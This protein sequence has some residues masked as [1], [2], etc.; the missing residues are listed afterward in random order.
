MWSKF[1]ER[2]KSCWKGGD[3]EMKLGFKRGQKG[4]TLVEIIIVLAIMAVLAAIVIPNVTNFLDEGKDTS[5]ESDQDALQV[6]VE[7]YRADT[8]NNPTGAWPTVD[9]TTGLPIDGNSDGDYLDAEDTRSFIDIET[10]GTDAYLKGA[11]DVRSA[12]NTNF[13]T[14]ATNTTGS[15]GWY[16]DSNGVVRSVYWDD[17][18]DTL[19]ENGA[20]TAVS[21]PTTAGTGY[22]VGDAVVLSAAPTGGVTATAEVASVGGT[23]DI[24]GVDVVNPGAGYTSAPTVDFSGEGN[25]DASGSTATIQT[26]V[27]LLG[28][29]QDG[30][31]P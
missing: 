31:Y 21:T 27:E 1:G 6:A 8:T 12:D 28:G 18:G 15:Y 17:D 20:V 9:G 16:I 11:D 23:G 24:T 2:I 22:E 10:L 30:V 3:T 25:G 29:F 26:T 14:T 13:N 4:F 7:G 19:I 5:W